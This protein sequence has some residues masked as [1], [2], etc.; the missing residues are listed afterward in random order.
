MSEK[1]PFIQTK[2]LTKR[3]QMGE[4]EV[5]ALDDVSLT[6]ELGEFV[7]VVGASGSGKST[8]LH[9]LGGVDRPTAGKVLFQGKD[10]FRWKE[11]KLVEYRKRQ[12]GFVF[13]SCYLISGLTVEENVWLPFL[14][15]GKREVKNAMKAEKE[16]VQYLGQI[17]GIGEKMNSLPSELSGGQ[18][19]R[20][21]ILR[22]LINHTTFLLCDEPTGNLDLETG[23]EVIH[24][25][26]MIQ[27][28]EGCAIVIVTH[29]RMV[30]EAA[31]RQIRIQDGRI[32]E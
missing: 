12:V 27:R 32:Y 17:L 14:M 13:Q 19:Q 15:K 9:M 7:A 30:A 10:I 20:A 6:V 26:K 3:Y 8:L 4:T 5:R 1:I 24:L 18:C 31:D 11:E 2:N 25:L 23:T 21:A 28:E 29:D 16:R 22:A